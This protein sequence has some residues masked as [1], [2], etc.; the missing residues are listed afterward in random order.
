MQLIADKQ[1]SFSAFESE[2]SSIIDIIEGYRFNRIIESYYTWV[3]KIVQVPVPG[4][5]KSNPSP[6]P[7][8]GFSGFLS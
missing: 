4:Y 1:V 8:F 5:N 6:N 7:R 2:F 3:G